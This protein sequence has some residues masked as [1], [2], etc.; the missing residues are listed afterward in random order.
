MREE[1]GD[2]VMVHSL[3]AG[4][5]TIPAGFLCLRRFPSPCLLVFVSRPFRSLSLSVLAPL[6]GC[7]YTHVYKWGPFF[8]NHIHFVGSASRLESG[9]QHPIG[10]CRFKDAI[11]TP[12]KMGIR[13]S[14]VFGLG[15]GFSNSA[16]LA[17]TILCLWYAV[18]SDARFDA[19][20]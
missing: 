5:D 1:G 19:I 11:R 14:L 13:R 18:F 8:G 17:M 15:M 4:D 6:C 9:S 7:V 16:L 10:T 20:I 12:Y 2:A 3:F